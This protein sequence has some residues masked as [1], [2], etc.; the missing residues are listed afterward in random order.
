MCVSLFIS[1]GKKDKLSIVQFGIIF[2][3]YTC[4][5]KDRDIIKILYFT[6]N[7]LWCYFRRLTNYRNFELIS[8]KFP[9]HQENKK[10]MK[11]FRYFSVTSGDKTN[12]RSPQGI[13]ALLIR[14]GDIS[15]TILSSL[16]IPSA[17]LIQC[18]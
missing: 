15:T 2:I 4:L 9:L 18:N 6:S 7:P 14:R 5:L 13:A 8:V 10:I 3:F 11:V 16:P 12:Y 1:L 17:L